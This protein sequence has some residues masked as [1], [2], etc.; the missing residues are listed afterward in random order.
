MNKNNQKF[1]DLCKKYEQEIL[2]IIEVEGFDVKFGQT[3][4]HWVNGK[5]KIV[6][7]REQMKVRVDTSS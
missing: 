5:I 1:I 2:A 3:I 7:R 4:L 6:E